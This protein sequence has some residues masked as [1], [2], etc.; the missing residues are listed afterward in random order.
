VDHE[1]L[2]YVT[3]AAQWPRTGCEFDQ[4]ELV[5]GELLFKGTDSDDAVEYTVEHPYLA[6]LAVHL[7]CAPVQ[8]TTRDL[9]GGNDEAPNEEA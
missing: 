3:T 8:S 5:L 7:L 2:A 1:Q 6:N 4:V 9:M